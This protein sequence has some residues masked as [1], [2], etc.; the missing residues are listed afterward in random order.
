MYYDILLNNFCKFQCKIN[1]RNLKIQLGNF[2]MFL[3]NSI[4]FESEKIIKIV[5][6][7]VR[8]NW[9]LYD[10]VLRLENVW[11]FNIM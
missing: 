5:Y 7:R 1:I 2:F 9:K 10:W 11:Y 3:I 8:F 4:W 6:F